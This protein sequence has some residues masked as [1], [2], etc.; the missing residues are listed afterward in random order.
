MSPFLFPFLFLP[1]LFLSMLRRAS[2]CHGLGKLEDL[3]AEGE[4]WDVN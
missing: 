1:F 3:F 4:T 2:S